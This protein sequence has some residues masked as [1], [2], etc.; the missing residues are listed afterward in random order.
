MAGRRSFPGVVAPNTR[1]DANRQRTTCRVI[2]P[3]GKPSLTLAETIDEVKDRSPGG[4]TFCCPF[5]I[6]G[7]TIS[8]K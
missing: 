6:M 7:W 3:Y 5:V 2:R 1:F 4:L 8:Q